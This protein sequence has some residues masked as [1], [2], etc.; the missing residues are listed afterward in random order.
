MGF[1]YLIMI[2]LRLNLFNLILA[3]IP[4]HKNK[5]GKKI[6]YIFKI[7]LSVFPLN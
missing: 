4:M 5:L 7:I 2:L 6:S 1:P 3:C